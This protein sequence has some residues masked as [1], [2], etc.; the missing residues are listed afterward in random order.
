MGKIQILD[1][2]I[3]GR[4]AAGEVVERP[5]SIVKELAENSIDAGAT[6]IAIAISEG[7]IK[8]IRVSDNGSGIAKEDMPLT[9]IK[10]AT[11]KIRSIDDLDRIYTM[12][13][14]GEAL[15]SI[16]AVSMMKI[17]SKTPE[18]E[19]GCELSV[20]GG[21]VERLHEIGLPDGTVILVENLF[22][23]TPARLKFLKKPAAETAAISAVVANLIISHPEI[24]FQYTSNGTVIYHSPGNANLLDAIISVEGMQLKPN[25]SEIDISLHDISIKGYHSM[26]S[27]SFKRNNGRVYVNTRPIRSK[28]LKTQLSM[29]T[30]SVC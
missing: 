17:R 10:H 1:E 9:I 15:A 22:Y 19:L 3:S 14:R 13:F 20:R 2:R 24:A 6:S 18:S 16:A 29:L 4:I 12:G 27:V 7:G 5:A 23:N 11:S 8:S 30:V 25:L 28:L 26:P 21:K